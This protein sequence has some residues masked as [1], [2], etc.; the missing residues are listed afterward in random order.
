M[1]LED[2]AQAVWEYATR[3]LASGS[4]ASPT[5]RLEQI[6]EAVWSY[7]TRELTATLIVRPDGTLDAGDFTAVSAATLHQALNDESDTSY[8]LN[9]LGNATKTVEFLEGTT[10]RATRSL[11]P[12][13][14]F[15]EFSFTLSS[16]ELA[17][18]TSWADI[19]I[20]LT[21]GSSAPCVI[22]FPPLQV[23][24]GDVTVKLRIKEQ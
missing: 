6:A 21:E 19:R 4:P 20:R 15:A 14:S 5:N 1:A 2:T 16:G 9:A 10:V 17:S 8:I 13:S 7:T 11:T 12:T 3:T 22:S 23:P 24:S 18:V